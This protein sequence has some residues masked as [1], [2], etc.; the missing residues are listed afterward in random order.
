LL[1]VAFEFQEHDAVAE[2]GVAGDDESS[3]DDGE[4]VEPEGGSN[5]D[6]EWELGY[7]LDVTAAATEVGG[8]AAQGDA[9]GLLMDFDLDLDGVARMEAALGF[10]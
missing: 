6:A 9:G 4:A 2:L 5:V 1:G 10:G 8:Y 3:N 7:E